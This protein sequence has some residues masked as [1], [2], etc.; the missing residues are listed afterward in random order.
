V[1]DAVVDFLTGPHE[2]VLEIL[3]KI[4]LPD[5]FRRSF[6]PS[7]PIPIVVEIVLSRA[8][9]EDLV[10][11]LG[12]GEFVAEFGHKRKGPL[13]LRASFPTLLE[14]LSKFGQFLFRL[15]CP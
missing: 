1:F 9:L 14:L 5:P 4:Y 13:I 12:P 10:P 7:S 6:F 8:G 3:E 11:G 15:S 2:A